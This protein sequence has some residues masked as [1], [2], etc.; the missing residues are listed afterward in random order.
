[1]RVMNGGARNDPVYFPGEFNASELL[2][3]LAD[4]AYITDTDRRIVFWNRAAQ[5]ITGWGAEEV[6]GHTCGDKLLVYADSLR[7]E[8]PWQVEGV[9]LKFQEQEIKVRV[10]FADT[11]FHRKRRRTE[12]HFASAAKSECYTTHMGDSPGLRRSLTAPSSSGCRVSKEGRRPEGT[13]ATLA[14]PISCAPYQ[15]SPY[16]LRSCHQVATPFQRKQRSTCLRPK[17]GP[18][19]NATRSCCLG[20]LSSISQ[21]DAGCPGES[22]KSHRAYMGESWEYPPPSAGP[23]IIS[24]AYGQSP[25]GTRDWNRRGRLSKPSTL[26][27]APTNRRW[28]TG[29]MEN[30]RAKHAQHFE[31]GL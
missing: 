26:L 30:V 1:M 3:L 20:S 10:G 13:F 4:G 24:R 6:V 22:W 31:P 29:T 7:L 5:R 8:A 27:S 16:A 17:R 11:P 9:P 23:S 28:P 25:A 12:I 18:A 14:M 19:N 15:G 2:N 21:T